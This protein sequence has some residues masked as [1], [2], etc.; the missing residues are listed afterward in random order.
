MT[1]AEQL[2]WQR[3]EN[4]RKQK[5]K[6]AGGANAPTAKPHDPKPDLSKMSLAE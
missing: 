4:E 3:A 1:L 2:Q 6:E 5:E